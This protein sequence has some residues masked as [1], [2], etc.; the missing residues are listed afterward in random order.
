[1]QP[2]QIPPARLRQFASGTGSTGRDLWDFYPNFKIKAEQY[3]LRQP[4][5][6]SRAIALL[7]TR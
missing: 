3:S 6:R 1:M 2:K 4:L 5:R 7:N